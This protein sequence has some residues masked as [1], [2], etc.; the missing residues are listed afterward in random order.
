MH[1]FIIICLLAAFYWESLCAREMEPF[2]FKHKHII[3]CV[4]AISDLEIVLLAYQRVSA[5]L[6]TLKWMH[7][8]FMRH[9]CEIKCSKI[10]AMD[11]AYEEF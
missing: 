11:G 10:A 5:V 3:L 1:A 2:S 8:N 9:L 7:K 4:V 6:E